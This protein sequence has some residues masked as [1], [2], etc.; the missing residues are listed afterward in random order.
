MKKRCPICGTVQRCYAYVGGFY[1]GAHTLLEVSCVA[2]ERN[3]AEMVDLSARLQKEFWVPP[4]EKRTK[5]VVIEVL[6]GVADC[7]KHP[8]D[9]DVEILDYDNCPENGRTK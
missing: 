5:K 8:R 2:S 3:T 9:V 6:G 1:F 7:T 4:Y